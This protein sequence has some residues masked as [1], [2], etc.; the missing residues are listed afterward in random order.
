MGGKSPLIIFDDVDLVKVA[1]QACDAVFFNKGENCIAAGRIFVESYIHDAFLE[2]VKENAEKIVIGDSLDR[3]TDH[4]PQNHLAH[5]I[6]LQKFVEKSL[7]EGA[8]LV[9]GGKRVNRKG[10]FF[11]P[12]ILCDVEEGT[13]AAREESFGPIMIVSKFNK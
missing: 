13:F 11:E 5:L 7:A 9:Y 2:R 10:L 8:K 1:R 12:T 4:G 6:S 3:K